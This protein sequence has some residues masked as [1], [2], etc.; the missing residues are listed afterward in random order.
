MLYRRIIIAKG[1]VDA[2]NIYHCEVDIVVY[3]FLYIVLS[4]VNLPLY[5]TACIAMRALTEHLCVVIAWSD[6]PVLKQLPVS[7]SIRR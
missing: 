4:E 1:V 6:V 5:Q 2:F 3:V 7:L